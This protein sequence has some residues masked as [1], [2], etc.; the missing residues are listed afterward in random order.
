MNA[1]ET[2]ELLTGAKQDIETALWHNRKEGSMDTPKGIQ[3]HVGR[4]VDTLLVVLCELDQDFE[5]IKKPVRQRAD[6]FDAMV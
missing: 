4:A 6:S 1:Q 5:L 2:E 3:K